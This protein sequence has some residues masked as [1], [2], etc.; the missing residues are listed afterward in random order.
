MSTTAHSTRI[1]K[2]PRPVP[3]AVPASQEVKESPLRP[4]QLSAVAPTPEK[5]DHKNK[6]F[7]NM[8]NQESGL[9]FLIIFSII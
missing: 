8:M 9:N 6:R 3:S 5:I 2:I 1:I 4:A 7:T